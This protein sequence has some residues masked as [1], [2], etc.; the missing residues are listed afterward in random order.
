MGF[1][2]AGDNE[3]D[4]LLTEI[5]SEVR[6]LTSYTVRSPRPS[7]GVKEPRPA[8]PRRKTVKKQHDIDT[9]IALQPLRSEN[10][11]L[12]RYNTDVTCKNINILCLY[13]VSVIDFLL[14]FHLF[15][16]YFHFRKLRIANQRTRDLEEQLQRANENK[17]ECKRTDQVLVA[18]KAVE[19]YFSKL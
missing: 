11:D 1:S 14:T 12:R 15:Y 3:V 4:R 19:K 2:V 7:P 10:S 8:S 9:E 17:K 6:L 5:E 16:T 13:S 18:G